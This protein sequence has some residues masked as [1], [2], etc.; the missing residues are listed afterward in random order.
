MRNLIAKLIRRE[1]LANEEHLVLVLKYKD[2]VIGRLWS[3]KNKYY[4][5]YDNKFKNTDLRPLTGFD[6][7]E[8]VYESSWLFPYFE[9]RIPDLNRVDVAV[10]AKGEHLN[11]SSSPLRKLSVFGKKTINDPYELTLVPA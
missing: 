5:Q 9:V 8:K 2:N 7:L 1:K 4:F 11:N 3:D 10:M 6:D